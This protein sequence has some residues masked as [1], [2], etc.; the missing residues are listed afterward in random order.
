MTTATAQPRPP[1][2]EEM[3]QEAERLERD[4]PRWI[5]LFG[6]YTRELVAFPRFPVPRGTIVAARHPDALPAR[7][8]AVEQCA[9]QE[10]AWQ[11]AR[12]TGAGLR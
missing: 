2:T 12:E 1:T 7:M 3:R 10:A 8:R 4:N 6:I 11:Q 5:I 9:G